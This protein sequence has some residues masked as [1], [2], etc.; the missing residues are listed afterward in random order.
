M[1]GASHRQ[2]ICFGSVFDQSGC[3]AD[4]KS[5]HCNSNLLPL[6]NFF[7]EIKELVQNT[8]SR[9]FSPL[10][11]LILNTW[12]PPSMK[13]TLSFFIALSIL[14]FSQVLCISKED[15]LSAEEIQN[16]LSSSQTPPFISLFG[17]PSFPDWFLLLFHPGLIESWLLLRSLGKREI[18]YGSSVRIQMATSF[19]KYSFHVKQLNKLLQTLALKSPLPRC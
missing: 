6:I 1:K 19:Y 14:L 8:H 18:T 12:T 5:T 4:L 16:E 13:T 7:R 15:I 9:L 10:K 11:V 17:F 3:F 2:G